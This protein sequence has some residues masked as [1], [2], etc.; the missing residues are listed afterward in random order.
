MLLGYFGFRVL[1]DFD[2][3]VNF[4][5]SFVEWLFSGLCFVIGLELGV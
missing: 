4:G 5:F 1:G 2:F 3:W